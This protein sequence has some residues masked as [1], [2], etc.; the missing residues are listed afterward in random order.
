MQC[1]RRDESIR[2]KEFEKKIILEKIE[3]WQI[4]GATSMEISGKWQYK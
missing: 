4:G 3:L 1:V 2:I